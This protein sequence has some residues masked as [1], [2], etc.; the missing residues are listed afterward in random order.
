M[1]VPGASSVVPSYGTT[2]SPDIPTDGTD[3][4]EARFGTAADTD[5]D[6]EGVREG[7][8]ATA[9]EAAGAEAAEAVAAPAPAGATAGRAAASGLQAAST[10]VTAPASRAAVARGTKI[11]VMG[12]S[13]GDPPGRTGWGWPGSP[14]RVT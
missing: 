12:S 3:R 6:G 4:A 13:E 10:A 8:G 11:K 1:R 14:A 2:R 7:D 5:G 9:P